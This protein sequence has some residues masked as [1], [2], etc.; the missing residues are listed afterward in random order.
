MTLETA[1]TTLPTYVGI[2]VPS[3]ILIEPIPKIPRLLRSLLLVHFYPNSWLR[4]LILRLVLFG[5]I[6]EF[7]FEPPTSLCF[8]FVAMSV[9]QET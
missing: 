7:K 1:V 4:R 8:V 3:F 2:V 6:F 9:F 5:F